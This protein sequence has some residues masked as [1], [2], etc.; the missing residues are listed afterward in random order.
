MT[1]EA[2]SE[3]LGAFAL[4]AV[5]LEDDSA[6]REHLVSCARCQSELA[7]F[8]EVAG[9]LANTGGNAPQHVW[10][11]IAEQMG[12]AGA[13][14]GGGADGGKGDPNGDHRNDRDTVG[15]LFRSP[16]PD[17]KRRSTG[18][19]GKK[20]L[21]FVVPLGTAAALIVITVLGLQI[22]RMNHRIGQLDAIAANQGL[23]QE[24]QAALLNPQAKRIELTSSTTGS[25]GA[26]SGSAGVAELVVLPSGPGFLINHEMPVLPSS[27]TYQLWG[28]VGG[29]MISIGLLGNRPTDVAMTIGQPAAFGFY[30]VTVEHAGGSV[31]PTLPPVAQSS[32]IS[33]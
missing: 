26:T 1:H 3:L 32:T 12:D 15:K 23:S 11:R 33:A 17:R 30:A 9:L 7:Q 4:D 10:E 27:E 14:G 16:A 6:I 8:H 13:Q 20:S 24:V 2:A 5:E 18:W 19:W 21:R 29:H 28:Q 25:N 31:S 22:D